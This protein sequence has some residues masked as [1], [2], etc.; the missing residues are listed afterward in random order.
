MEPAEFLIRWTIRFAM[1]FY[2]T[3]LTLRCPSPPWSRW[4]WTVGCGLYLMHVCAAFQFRHHWSH[5]DAYLATAQQSEAVVGLYW[6]GGI[7]ANYFFTAVWL[8]DAVWWWL[9]PRAYLDRPRW[10]NAGIHGYLGFIAFNATVV[11]AQGWSQWFG[12]L[13]CML[14]I[15]TWVLERRLKV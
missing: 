12:V 6:G 1:V 10:L 4:A 5:T 15:G 14:L 9:R 11:F 8:G 3:A 13:A 7:Y 2:V